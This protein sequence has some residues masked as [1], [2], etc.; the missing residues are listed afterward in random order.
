MGEREMILVLAA[1]LFFSMTSL[2]VNRFC[3]QNDE[4]MLQSEF[5]YYAI[6]LA[7]SIIEEAKTRY[8]DVAVETEP[9]P[10]LSQLPNLFTYPL[11]PRWNESYPNFSDVDD[12][13]GLNL[14]ITN[15]TNPSARANY[16]V[17]VQVGYVNESNIDQVV[18]YKT[19]YKKMTVIVT[20]AY[21][22]APVVLSHVFSYY[23][24]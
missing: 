14:N 11:G 12:Y 10:S 13:H 18:T 1:L 19:F 17:R 2:T 22:P 20:S 7:Q 9:P 4:T 23:E 24:F 3:L 15:N 16:T 6:S 5:Q 21:L 8:F